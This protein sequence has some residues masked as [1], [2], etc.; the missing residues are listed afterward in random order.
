MAA[1]NLAAVL[2]HLADNAARHGAGTLEIRAARAGPALRV[3]VRDDGSGVS[4]GNRGR[5]FDSFFTT[6][7]EDGGTGMGLPIVRALLGA[8]GGSA[9]LIDTERGRASF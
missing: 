4:P 9:A 5:I 3:E 1:E 8:H 6:R 2:S 7:R